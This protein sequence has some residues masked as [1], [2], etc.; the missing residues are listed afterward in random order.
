[1]I[2]LCPVQGPWASSFLP[3]FVRSPKTK[4]LELISFSIFYSDMFRLHPIVLFLC[5]VYI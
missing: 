3:A 4:A 1:M 5:N 2:L